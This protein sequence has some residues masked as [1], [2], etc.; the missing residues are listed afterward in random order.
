MLLFHKAV[1]IIAGLIF[2]F[3]I[4]FVVFYAVKTKNDSQVFPPS[5]NTCPDLWATSIETDS[6]NPQK[7]TTTCYYVGYNSGNNYISP[8]NAL[9]NNW[10]QTNQYT[11]YNDDGGKRHSAIFVDP[12]HK[13]G[14]SGTNLCNK[15]NWASTNNIAW[16][17]VNEANC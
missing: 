11:F 12:D 2:I 13:W 14:I 1:L 5:S 3:A 15:K 17:G 16:S 10:S 7:T 4:A 9:I 6:S 8:D